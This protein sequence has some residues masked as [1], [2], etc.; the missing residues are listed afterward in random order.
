MSIPNRPEPFTSVAENAD[1]HS[2]R[3]VLLAKVFGVVHSDEELPLFAVALRFTVGRAALRGVAMLIMGTY[4]LFAARAGKRLLCVLSATACESSHRLH[5][6]F[7]KMVHFSSTGE[8]TV[9][10]A[11]TGCAGVATI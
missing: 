3:G 10:G 9:S 1:A 2:V 4:A 6:W 11:V 8:L 5:L 7:E